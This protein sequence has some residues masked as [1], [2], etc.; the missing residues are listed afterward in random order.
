MCTF[1]SASFSP[2]KVFRIPNLAYIC[3]LSL[4]HSSFLPQVSLSFPPFLI[5]AFIL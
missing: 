3:R 1:V 2:L 4:L 5:S